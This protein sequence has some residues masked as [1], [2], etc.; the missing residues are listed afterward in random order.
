MENRFFIP[1]HNT[2]HLNA[3]A[4]RTIRLSWLRTPLVMCIKDAESLLCTERLGEFFHKKAGN[5]GKNLNSICHPSHHCAHLSTGF[6]V[7][8]TWVLSLPTLPPSST[9]TTV[10]PASKACPLS[11]SCPS[12]LPNTLASV[13]LIFFPCATFLWFLVFLFPCWLTLLCFPN[14]LLSIYLQK[15]QTSW[16]TS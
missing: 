7:W 9:Q 13:V 12:L 2:L 4:V 6:P 10:D 14:R 8:T 1:A 16:F 3:A 11:P 15:F 5:P